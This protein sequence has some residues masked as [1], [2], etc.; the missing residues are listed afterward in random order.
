MHN[1][2]LVTP[3]DDGL[4]FSGISSPTPISEISRV[5]SQN[6]LAINLFGW[7]GVVTVLRT[8]KSTN[9]PINLLLL[10]EEDKSHYVWVK[11]L[12]RLLYDQNKAKTKKHFCVR[13]LQGFTKEE[14]LQ[15][16]E[17]ACVNEQ[18]IRIEMPKQN[19]I[20]FI[21]YQKQMKVPYVIYADFESIIEPIHTAL[22]NPK[23]S[24]TTKTEHHN[25]CSF[26]YMVVCSDGTCQDPVLYRGENATEK[27]LEALEAEEK[28]IIAKLKNRKKM[29][30]SMTQEDWNVYH[31]ANCWICEKPFIKLEKWTGALANKCFKCEADLKH[32]YK[33]HDETGK[34]IGVCC[35]KCKPPHHKVLDHCHITGKFRGPAHN[36]CNLKLRINPNTITIP[37]VFHNLRGYDSH[38]LMQS[39]SKTGGSLSCIPNNMEKYISF[40]LRQLRFIDSL[41]FLNTSLEKLVEGC[42]DFPITSKYVDN[43]LLLRK[44]VYPYEYMSNWGKFEET[45]LPPIEAFYSKLTAT[46]ISEESYQHAKT[47]WKAFNCKNLG[48]YHDLY[49]RNDVTLLADVFETYRNA[50]MKTYKLDPAHYYTSPGLSW[51]ALLKKTQVE[52]ELITDYD[53]YL[54]IEKGLRGG[55]S[56]VSKRFAKANNKYLQDYDPEQPS[57]YIQYLDANN[58]YGW[59]MSQPLPTGNFKWSKTYKTDGAKGYILEVDL[60]YPKELHESHNSYPLAPEKLKVPYEWMSPYQKS[61]ATPDVTAEKLIPNLRNKEKYVLHYRNLQ[62]YCDLGMRVTKVH[63]VL[64]FDQSPWMEPYITMNTELRKKAQTDFE[65][66]LYKLMN[67]SVFG[68]TMEN[69]RK[70]VD[71]RLIRKHE[72][73]KL[74]QLIAK[75]TFA[76]SKIFDDDLAAIHMHKDKLLLNRPM[77]CWSGSILDLAKLLMYDFFYNQLQR[78]YGSNVEVLYTDTD[79]LVLHIFTDDVYDDMRNTH[80]WYDTSNYKESHPLFSNANKKVLGKMKDECAGTPISEFV[81][82]RAKMYSI[83]KADSEHIHRA[84]GI[85]KSTVQTDPIHMNNTSNPCLTRWIKKSSSM[86]WTLFKPTDIAYTACTSQRQVSHQ[87]T[88][89]VGLKMMVFIPWRT[90][91]K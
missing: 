38:L 9:K 36:A 3:T 85:K 5:E 30:E 16:H 11:N 40:Q 88:P 54:F 87:W 84:K 12:S 73:T 67:N 86:E 89:S 74:R 63:R 14:L 29:V 26:C 1:D 56:M 48:D 19:K 20:K 78:Q 76:G 22:P 50:C 45:Q 37:V 91:M 44:G 15:K 51:D 28:A 2:A 13:C 10:T 24:N 65:R 27:F 49:L 61:L 69:Q 90:D 83:L 33:Y 39:I 52:L 80:E 21:N 62:L 72:E 60:E 70:R 42:K 79:S 46:S 53:M 81:G 17:E 77:Y 68:K 8:S 71:V 35:I 31:T 57:S 43:A 32:K 34:F 7:D 58:L 66:D 82:L 6:N 64:E 55:I 47:V 23:E 75:P 25:G 18:P 41:Q 59:A 4:D